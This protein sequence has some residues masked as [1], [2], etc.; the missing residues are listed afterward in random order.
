MKKV[1]LL[2][3]VVFFVP[4]LAT[5]FLVASSSEANAAVNVVCFNDLF[6]RKIGQVLRN[7]YLSWRKRTGNSQGV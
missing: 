5:A 7:Q 4:L 2:L 6:Q 3:S 1:A